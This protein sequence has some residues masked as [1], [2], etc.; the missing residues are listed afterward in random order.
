[1]IERK[2]FRRV[3]I[4]KKLSQNSQISLWTYYSTKS[5]APMKL[6]KQ[7]EAWHKKLDWKG[8][9]ADPTIYRITN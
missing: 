4:S 9:P 2:V 8:K 7:L 3:I 1:M 5:K 6:L